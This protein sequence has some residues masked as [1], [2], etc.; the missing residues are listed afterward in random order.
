MQQH[1]ASYSLPELSDEANVTPRTVRY[2]I[3]QGLLPSPG[4]TGPGTRYG[5]EHLNRLKLI[6]QLQRRH[7]PLAEIRKQLAGLRQEE[8]A[9][10][11]QESAKERHPETGKS[12]LD[13][14][15]SV[16]GERGADPRPRGVFSTVARQSA[17]AQPRL[18]VS[19]PGADESP[20]PMTLGAVEFES[21]PPQPERSEWE[22]IVL[23]PDLELH[24]RRPLS[25][26]LNRIVQR[27]VSLAKQ[28][29]QED[30]S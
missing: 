30:R 14:V 19:A 26:Q 10:L 24:I 18:Q 29:L 4:T 8:I 28:A 23:S 5:E 21:P 22:R 12:A 1:S 6:K 11:L 25:R 7:L 9:T 2:Y 16:L 3:R 13:Y 17:A 27:L 20:Q 15:R